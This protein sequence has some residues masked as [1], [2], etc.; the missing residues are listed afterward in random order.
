MILTIDFQSEIPIYQQIRAAVVAEIA[1]GRVKTGEKLPPIRTLANELKVNLHTVNK[2]YQ[3]LEQEGLIK[4]LGRRGA[5]VGEPS[6]T[7]KQ[8]TKKNLQQ[9]VTEAVAYGLGYPELQKV[10]QQTCQRLKEGELIESHP[11]D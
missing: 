6:A 10:V 11:G 2:A 4:L 3:Q 7:D 5:I 9:A 1:A 8:Q